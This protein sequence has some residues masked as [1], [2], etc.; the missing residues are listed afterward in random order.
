MSLE[1][2]GARL[3]LVATFEERNSA[4]QSTSAR[5]Q[6]RRT[7]LHARPALSMTGAQGC[8]GGVRCTNHVPRQ[9]I[10]GVMSAHS[11]GTDKQS[12]SRYDVDYQEGRWVVC[13]G[14]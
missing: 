14:S 10:P 6:R 11:K 5:T 13:P 1:A 3:E 8:G 4:S 12:L 9:A 2:L 7:G